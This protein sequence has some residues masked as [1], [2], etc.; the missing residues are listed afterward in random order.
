MTPPAKFGEASK[1]EDGAGQEGER[2]SK[3]KVGSS[4]LGVVWSSDDEVDEEKGRVSCGNE[5]GEKGSGGVWAEAGMGKVSRGSS[6]TTP[7]C[8]HGRPWRGVGGLL[9]PAVAGTPSTAG[10]S[11]VGTPSTTGHAGVGTPY[12]AS[13]PGYAQGTPCGGD[14]TPA[15]QTPPQKAS[16]PSRPFTPGWGLSPGPPQDQTPPSGA[17]NLSWGLSP[18]P[19]QG[20]PSPPEAKSLSRASTGQAAHARQAKHITGHEDQLDHLSALVGGWGAL[21]GGGSWGRASEGIGGLTGTGAREVGQV[22]YRAVVKLRTRDGGRRSIVVTFMQ[23]G[24]G[25][26]AFSQASNESRTSPG[27]GIHAPNAASGER[28]GSRERAA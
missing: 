19:S 17:H 23:K 20:A 9:S 13:T 11:V 14:G 7:P 10:H 26:Q 22:R 27:I 6:N 12:A 4:N 16:P 3:S 21:E 8:D 28:R 15:W 18:G 25:A 5:A 24:W 1:Y 2:G